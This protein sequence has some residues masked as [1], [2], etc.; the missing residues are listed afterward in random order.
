VSPSRAAAIG[1]LLLVALVSFRAHAA[2]TDG[3]RLAPLPWREPAPL[4]RL[5]LQL[6]FETAE[7]LTPGALA[8]GFDLLYSNSLL[9]ARSAN[10]DLDVD[11]ETAQ[12][13]V[14]LRYGLGRRLEAELG[15]PVVVD[16]GGFLDR[17]IEIV[18]GW[19]H[20]ENPQ[21]TWVPR[22]TRRFHLTRPDGSGIADDGPAA[23]LGDLWASLKVSL[24][25]PPEAMQLALRGA[26]KLPTGRLPFGSEEVDL[27]ASLLASWSSR[28]TAVWFEVDV[29]FPTAD[30]PAVH[31]HTRPYGAAQ[32]GVSQRLGD[33]VALV[34]QGSGH[35]SPMRSTGFDQLD[36][37]TAYLLVGVDVA[38]SR[39]VR[40]HAAVAENIFSP[41]RGADITFPLG[42]EAS[43]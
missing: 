34:V 35:L 31:I 27:G 39:S 1:L 19:F 40:L 32:L 17:P 24:P 37:P 21:R 15:I 43:F 38:L 26:V 9:L 14:R 2:D 42:V 11:V 30:L 12:P 4:A 13:T 7:V 22:N 10:L 36:R 3:A 28:H 23:G 33:R 5:F 16:Y 8:V 25:T 20:A 41:Y 29:L 18:E 6:P